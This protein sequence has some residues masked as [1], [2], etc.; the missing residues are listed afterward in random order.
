[1]DQDQ[2]L[3]MY[4]E[5][6]MI[7]FPLYEALGKIEHVI[8]EVKHIHTKR[9]LVNWGDKYGQKWHTIRDLGANHVREATVAEIVLFGVKGGEHG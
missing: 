1:M 4:E 6:Q 7:F 8:K 3:K 9:Y 2:P 5:G